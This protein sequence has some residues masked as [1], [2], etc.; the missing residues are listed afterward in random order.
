MR[1]TPSPGALQEPADRGV[2]GVEGGRVDAQLHPVVGLGPGPR[3]D[4]SVAVE[5]RSRTVA[6]LLR[7]AVGEAP[8][9]L[10]GMVAALRGPDARREQLHRRQGL[11]MGSSL[12]AR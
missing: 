9:E 4:L 7:Q 8:G 5:H 11:A 10:P 6:E 12:S 2:A 1:T 3:D